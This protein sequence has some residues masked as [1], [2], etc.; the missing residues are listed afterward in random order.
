MTDF[1]RKATEEERLG[2]HALLKLRVGEVDGWVD[3]N[4]TDLQTTKALLKLILKVVI[5][6]NR[7]NN[8]NF[9]R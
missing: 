1:K 9:R 2:E 5:I 8:D 7:R 6:L 3:T 4:V